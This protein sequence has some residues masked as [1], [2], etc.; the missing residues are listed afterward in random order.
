MNSILSKKLLQAIDSNCLWHIQRIYF[1]LELKLFSVMN[2]FYMYSEKDKKTNKISS[3]YPGNL[4]HSFLGL[5]SPNR[6]SL[7]PTL[8]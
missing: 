4:R 8:L 6:L 5:E 3:K 7:F 2:Y 1:F